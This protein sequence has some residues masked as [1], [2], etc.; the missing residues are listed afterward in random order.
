MFD[1]G[2]VSDLRDSQNIVG[3]IH[4]ESAISCRS[5]RGIGLIGDEQVVALRSVTMLNMQG[6]INRSKEWQG[7]DYLKG[8]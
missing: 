3:W 5:E 7:V 1:V 8:L 2:K 6:A 4:R